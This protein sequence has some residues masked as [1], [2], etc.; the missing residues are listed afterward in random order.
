VRIIPGIPVVALSSDSLA[1]SDLITGRVGSGVVWQRPDG[2]L[3]EL[4][5]T[6]LWH[7][8][9]VMGIAFD[10]GGLT[11]GTA[12]K[13]RIGI[14]DLGADTLAPPKAAVEFENR[15][16]GP[17][18]FLQQSLALRALKPGI[19][20]LSATVSSEGRSIRRDRRI[21]IAAP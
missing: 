10:I 21:T 2:H 7:S 19:Y 12:Y 13:V 15:A 14:A 6:N 17:R 18:T 9:D 3:I 20:L 11:P 1:V 16:E 4:Q 5:P 8:G